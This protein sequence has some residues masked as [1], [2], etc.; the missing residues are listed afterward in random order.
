MKT[1]I[2]DKV[3]PLSVTAGTEHTSALMNRKAYIK[4]REGGSPWI[5]HPTTGRVLPW[6]GNPLFQLLKE[7]FG[8]YMM[9]LPPGADMIPYGKAMP[10]E[11]DLNDRSEMENTPVGGLP[12][13][14]QDS[15]I[16]SRLA[17]VIGERQRLMPEGSYTT[18]L[19]QNG[20]DKIRKKL[21]EETVELLLAKDIKDVVYETADL[22]YHVLVLLESMKISWGS[23]ETELCRRFDE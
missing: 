21:G 6:P 13:T 14:A 17:A 3:W 23:I 5:V 8:G 22:I 4:S 7:T 1:A 18:H 2:K 11:L 12:E 9:T 19:F 15:N 10:E 16:L 20:T